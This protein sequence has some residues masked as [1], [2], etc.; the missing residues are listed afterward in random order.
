[1]AEPVPASEKAPLFKRPQRRYHDRHGFDEI[2]IKTVPYYKRDEWRTVTQ[3]RFFQKGKERFVKCYGSMPTVSIELYNEMTQPATEL[4]K[5]PEVDVAALCDQYGCDK[6]WTRSF[7]VNEQFCASCANPS[8]IYNSMMA[9]EVRCYCDEHARR[10]DQ[11]FED[12]DK[13]LTEIPEK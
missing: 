5:S 4:Y 2:R 12:C 1:M 9:R 11:A 13:N 8:T 7:T 3:A 6:P 10:G